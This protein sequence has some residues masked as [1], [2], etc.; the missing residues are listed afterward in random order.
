MSQLIPRPYQQEAATVAVESN[1]IINLP[2]GSGKTLIAALVHEKLRS[3]MTLIVCASVAVIEQHTQFFHS[4]GI[5]NVIVDTAAGLKARIFD[6][7]G[8]GDD[9]ADDGYFCG[10][11]RINLIL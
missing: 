5:R 1:R 7:G 11:K 6:Y 8:V 9:G 4:R 2:T 3:R 10:F